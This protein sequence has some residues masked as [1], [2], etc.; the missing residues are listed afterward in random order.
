MIRRTLCL[1]DQ[2][3]YIHV[4]F[5]FPIGNS[6]DDEQRCVVSGY[7]NGDIKMFDLRMM[8]LKWEANV[9]SGVMLMSFIC[10][11]SNHSGMCVFRCVQSSLIARTYPWTKWSPLHLKQSFMSTISEHIIPKRDLLLLRKRY[12]CHFKKKLWRPIF[13]NLRDTLYMMN[14]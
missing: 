12:A 10:C 11:Y 8:C 6:Y 1:L 7:D 13:G 3:M 5:N 14:R 2:V 4:C 9:K